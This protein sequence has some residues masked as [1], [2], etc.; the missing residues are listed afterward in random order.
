MAIWLTPGSEWR[1]TYADW[2][3]YKKLL[4]VDRIVKSRGRTPPEVTAEGFTPGAELGTSIAEHY[5]RMSHHRLELPAHFD[6]DLKELF[7][8]GPA[9]QGSDWEAS[10]RFLTRHRRA[11]VAKIAYW[12]G[13]NEG[14]VRSLIDHFAERCKVLDLWVRPQDLD[15]VRLELMAYATTLCMNRL[16]KGDFVI[17]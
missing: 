10:D 16:Y 7:A 2:G 5:R 1:T 3:C 11:M 13:L 6:G 15:E 17:K 12:T 4:Y 8:R 9:P 14:I